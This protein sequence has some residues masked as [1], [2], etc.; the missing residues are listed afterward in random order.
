MKFRLSSEYGELS[1][2][3]DHVHRGIDLA[4]P[5]GTTLRSIAE[6]TVERIADYGATNLGKG[7]FI[8]HDDGNLSIYGHMKDTSAVKVGE[9]VDAGEII[10]IS[11]NTGSSTGPH[12]H[13][14]IKDANGNFVD[15][16]PLADQVDAMSG[17]VGDVATNFG[18][19]EPI[20]GLG[21]LLGSTLRESTK[22]KA[23]EI[24]YG[25]LEAGL[26]VLAE[27]IQSVALV[28]SGIAI[29]L[30]VAG[31]KD[32]AR[33]TGVLFTANTLIKYLLGGV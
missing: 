5:E 21:A 12:L 30:W 10:G 28:G 31:W 1:P 17:V 26:E 27:V 20:G 13:Y 18:I 9:H 14:A 19:F 22:E 3:R 2:I 15:P 16:T 32:G 11:G 24:I 8:R 4:M 29:I 6:G 23:K 7:V 25:F 33:W